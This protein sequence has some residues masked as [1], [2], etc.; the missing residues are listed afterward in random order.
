VVSPQFLFWPVGKD[1][2]MARLPFLSIFSFLLLIL[3]Y[4]IFGWNVASASTIWSQSVLEQFQNWQLGLKEESIM[5]IIHFFALVAI[6]LT[7]LA[8]TAPI[9]L[10]TFFVGSWIKS[11]GQSIIS[12][13]IWSFLFVLMLRWLNYFAEFL[14]LL[15]SGILGRI[16]LRQAGLGQFKA[17]FILTLLCVFSF[18]GGV[19]GY[20]RW[21]HII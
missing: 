19:F 3:A 4:G 5:A 7:S 18:G 11:F 2:P 21:N 1:A 9:S 12:M 10:M 17:L 8:L 20:F 16:E 13:I 14:V 15:C 6:V